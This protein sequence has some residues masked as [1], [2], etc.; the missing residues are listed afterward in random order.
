MNEAILKASINECKK[1]LTKLD[2]LVE[3]NTSRPQILTINKF[4]EEFIKISQKKDYLAIYNIA[5][6]NRDYDFLLE[7]DSFIQISCS[8]D[9]RNGV[10][11]IR[12]AYYENPR[13]IKSYEEFLIE[14]FPEDFL[15][16]DF[17]GEEQLFLRDYEQYKMEALLK[18]SVT[19]IRYDYDLEN[20]MPIVHPI[21]HIHIGHNND[22]RIP[23]NKILSPL[24]F[25]IFVVR[26]VYRKRWL[27]VVENNKELKDYIL[28]L[29]NKSNPLSDGYFNNEEE[30][31]LYLT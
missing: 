18:A 23:I 27:D 20:F 14:H 22:V 11:L 31:L 29:K 12:Y 9:E 1:L 28:T 17:F 30:R 6:K 2:I 5:M 24:K 26:N 21:S 19:P 3:Y 4:S 8:L 10:K 25:I 13:K 15:E 16:E 7:D